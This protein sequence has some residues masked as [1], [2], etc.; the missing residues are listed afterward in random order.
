MEGCPVCTIGLLD[1]CKVVKQKRRGAIAFGGYDYY[2][3]EV[4]S[5][6]GTKLGTGVAIADTVK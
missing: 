4:K 6:L 3:I 2:S 1:M 5:L